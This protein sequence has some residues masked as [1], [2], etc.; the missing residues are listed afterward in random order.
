M[1]RGFVFF[2]VSLLIT[3][4][5]F[6]TQRVHAETEA[7]PAMEGPLLLLE[8]SVLE[9][10]REVG[11]NAVLTAQYVFTGTAAAF[12]SS[13]HSLEL[14]APLRATGGVFALLADGQEQPVGEGS[15]QENGGIT[16]QFSD[17][18]AL[19][20]PAEPSPETTGEPPETPEQPM[21]AALTVRFEVPCTIDPAALPEPDAEG[22]RRLSLPSGGGTVTVNILQPR[23]LRGPSGPQNGLSFADV[24]TMGDSRIIKLEND[25]EISPSDILYF[26]EGNI[27]A[28]ALGLLQNFTL[29]K[30]DAKGALILGNTVGSGGTQYEVILPAGLIVAEGADSAELIATVTGAAAGEYKFADFYYDSAATPKAWIVF[31]GETSQGGVGNFWTTDACRSLQNGSIEVGCQLDKD[32]VGTALTYPLVSSG[33]TVNVQIGNNQP[34]EHKAVKEGSFNPD[35]FRFEWKVT[36]TVGDIAQ[37]EAAP[38]LFSDILD[39]TMHEY[40][41]DSFYVQLNEGQNQACTPDLASGAQGELRYELSPANLAGHTLVKGDVVILTFETALTDDTQLAPRS[42]GA[43]NNSATDVKNQ[44][45]IYETWNVTEGA[46]KTE[47][48]TVSIR[49]NQKNWIVKSGTPDHANRCILW[50]VEIFTMDRHLDNLTLYDVFPA[51]SGL[52]LIKKEN[53]IGVAQGTGTGLSF[54]YLTFDGSGHQTNTASA[55]AVLSENGVQKPGSSPAVY[56]SFELAFPHLNS[57]QPHYANSYTVTYKTQ[58]PDSYYDHGQH[59]DPEFKNDV[60]LSFDWKVYGSG[61]PGADL[62]FTAPTASKGVTCHTNVLWKSVKTAYDPATQIIEWA[63][64]VNPHAATVTEGTI[65]DILPQ[66]N[67]PDGMMWEFVDW[68]SGQAIGFDQAGNAS[69][70]DHAEISSD[71][72]TLEIVLD[73]GANPLNQ[74]TFTYYFKTRVTNPNHIGYNLTEA[75]EPT[76]E[77]EASFSGVVNAATITDT[78]C[79]EATVKST[80]LEKAQG[81]YDYNTNEILWTVTLNQNAMPMTGVTLRDIVSKG[82]GYVTGSA[83]INTGGGYHSMG[84]SDV[85]WNAATRTLDLVVGSLADEET[86]RLQYRTKVDVNDA[87]LGFTTVASGSEI[88][89]T[90]SIEIFKRDD[91]ERGNTKVQANAKVVSQ[92][93][94]KSG[95]ENRGVVTYTVGINQH[96]LT[97]PALTLEDTLPEGFV[98]NVASLTLHNA[99]VDSSGV[100]SPTTSWGG[101]ARLNLQ[102]DTE[103]HKFS[104]TLPAGEGRYVLTYKC[105]ALVENYREYENN[106]RYLG[107][108]F[109]EQAAKEQCKVRVRGANAVGVSDSMANL[110]VQ[111]QDAVR[112]NTPIEN[113]EFEL[114]QQIGTDWVSAAT[115]STDAQGRAE[116]FPLDMSGTYRLVETRA[117]AGYDRQTA[118]AEVS[119]AQV[120]LDRHEFTLPNT[121]SAGGNSLTVTNKPNRA[122][123]TFTKVNDW[124][125]PLSGVR[126]TLTD[127]DTGHPIAVQTATSGQD[128]V[129][130]FKDIPVGSYTLAEV[131]HSCPPYHTPHNESF[132][133]T[134]AKN[135]SYTLTHKDGTP[136]QEKKVVNVVEKGE[137]P[138]NVF[139]RQ[140]GAPLAGRTFRLLDAFGRVVAEE[141]TNSQGLCV[142]RNIAFGEVFTIMEVDAGE[143]LPSESMTVAMPGAVG[144]NGSGEASVSV[145]W[146]KEKNTETGAAQALPETAGDGQNLP[147]PEGNLAAGPEPPRPVAAE[148]TAAHNSPQT[149]DNQGVWPW[150]AATAFGLLLCAVLWRRRRQRRRN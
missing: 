107:T 74:S 128:G 30:D 52:T 96:G 77:N 80:V 39:P 111:K 137:I 15:A 4:M 117:A 49:P 38:L 95:V 84:S 105:T 123:V 32:A 135:G 98:L 83:Q 104:F 36:Y 113:A 119:G 82:Q 129:V 94:H 120:P 115:A 143:Y 81:V 7:P 140:S 8:G 86:V 70:V 53:S 3:Q 97:L 55:P 66:G 13:S 112:G 146:P 90:N 134:V 46:V 14:P 64:Q 126:F 20:V 85:Q 67:L 47:E 133:V 56:S 43:P 142:F 22:Q 1:K 121:K 145:D 12:S 54:T 28:T 132:L 50:T 68:E 27:E 149:G 79:A 93:L 102:V 21:A 92:S 11:E 48:I 9:E 37:N 106:I 125:R 29:S 91:Y 99:T 2:L 10:N 34:A 122:N 24:V 131:A 69:Y 76:Y 62:T 147:L 75:E 5:G 59:T 116:F 58:V 42:N 89:L 33:Q 73:H 109:S 17:L 127:R 61:T 44:A 148:T 108:T 101:A 25:E 114:Q 51:S 18:T 87:T 57:G 136:V 26:K 124:D 31:N 41:T 60:W 71:K 16:L 138:L 6:F 88:T 100:F 23:A 110:V 144:Y 139:D 40:V 130:V 103:N 150:L 35:T 45:C 63:V 141:T 118:V 78:S 65:T 72:K 19:T